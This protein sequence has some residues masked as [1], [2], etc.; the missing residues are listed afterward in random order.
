MTSL[1]NTIGEAYTSNPGAIIV[2]HTS[3]NDMNNSAHTNSAVHV[4][5]YGTGGNDPFGASYND[6]AQTVVTGR[7]YLYKQATGTNPF[8]TAVKNAERTL[9]QVRTKT[10]DDF[11]LTVNGESIQV[12]EYANADNITNNALFYKNSIFEMQG[13]YAFIEYKVINGSGGAYVNLVFQ[14]LGTIP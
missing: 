3:S 6:G 8:E 12:Y 7:G 10:D 5:R 13:D 1:G 11:K 2:N 14:C 9:W 4:L